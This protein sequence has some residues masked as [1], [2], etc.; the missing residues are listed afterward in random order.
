[1]AGHARALLAFKN[2]GQMLETAK[3][4]IHKGISVR[5]VER[6]A[7]AA[8]RNKDKNEN[9][10]ARRETY[11]DEV[12]LALTNALGRKVKVVTAGAKNSG[13]LE[14]AFFDREDLGTLALALKQLED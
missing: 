12:E 9:R 5:E 4:I 11:F 2:E 3:L 1:L 13:T 6:L 7:K 8:E 10:K 14:I